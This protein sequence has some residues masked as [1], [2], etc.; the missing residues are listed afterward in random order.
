MNFR[1][2]QAALIGYD[3]A[4]FADRLPDGTRVVVRTRK[5]SKTGRI[6]EQHG[7]DYTPVWDQYR[8]VLDSGEVV[9]PHRSNVEQ[10]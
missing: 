9:F 1:A 3:A 4:A 2:R 10:S 5:G 8:V 6:K 7:R